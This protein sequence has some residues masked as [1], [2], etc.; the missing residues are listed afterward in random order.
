MTGDYSLP[1]VRLNAVRSGK[2][3]LVLPRKKNPTG[4]GWSGR[5]IDAVDQIQLYDLDLDIEEKHDVAKEHP[6]VVQ[7]LM[8][9][10]EKG[11]DELGDYNRIGKGARF[12][13]EGPYRK[14]SKKWIESK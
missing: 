12:Y 5:M 2:W 3:K 10:V 4:T 13:D 1:W 11:R 14:E 6:K 9:L 7:R 8:D